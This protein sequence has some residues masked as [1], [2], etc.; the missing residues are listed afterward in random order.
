MEITNIYVFIG[1]KMLGIEGVEIYF[2][3]KRNLIFVKLL[4]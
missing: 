2:F 3:L 1:I 4:K